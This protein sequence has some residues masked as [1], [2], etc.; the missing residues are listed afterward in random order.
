MALR[1]GNPIK[2]ILKD[3]LAVIYRNDQEKEYKSNWVADEIVRT[4]TCFT[5]GHALTPPRSVNMYFNQHDDYFERCRTGTFRLLKQHYRQSTAPPSAVSSAER[6]KQYHQKA[7][8]VYEN[9]KREIHYNG[10]RFLQKIRTDGGLAAAKSWLRPTKEDKPTK[11]FMKLVDHGKLELSLEALVLQHPWDSL[12]TPE[13][14]DVAR[15]RLAQ[16]GYFDSR[17]EEIDR[18]ELL[19]QEIDGE[20]RTEGGVVSVRIN[21]Y[22]RDPAAR[23][24]CIAYWGAQCCVCLFDFAAVYGDDFFEFIHVHHLIP[25]SSIGAEYKVNPIAHLRPVCPNCHAVIHRKRPCYC[26]ED[27]RRMMI[28]ARA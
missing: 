1:P 15:Q 22:E 21:R 26:I 4:G 10:T 18:T 19:P 16:Y 28:A 6:E 20:T 17:P 2:G 5:G 23:A 11:G 25:L 24:G 12:F 27:V 3:M 9:G 7:L 13:Q 14:L 8:E